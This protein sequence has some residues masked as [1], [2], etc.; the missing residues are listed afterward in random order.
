MR[1]LDRAAGVVGEFGECV[2]SKLVVCP[3]VDPADRRVEVFVDL[4]TGL[5]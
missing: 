5:S 2:V 4:V 1:W 3:P